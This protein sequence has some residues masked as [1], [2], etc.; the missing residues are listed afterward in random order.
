MITKNKLK[1]IQERFCSTIFCGFFFFRLIGGELPMY[2][3]I[4]GCFFNGDSGK[5]GQKN[6]TKGRK[7]VF[8]TPKLDSVMQLHPI[9]EGVRL[10]AKMSNEK[11]PW[12]FGV[13]RGLYYPIIYIYGDYYKP[14]QVS[15]LTNQ[16]NG[17]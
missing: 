1:K 8:L 6:T 4:I 16:Y 7:M 10:E 2:L 13:Y 12:L 17:K 15:L 11:K 14:L 3:E 5:M 9:W